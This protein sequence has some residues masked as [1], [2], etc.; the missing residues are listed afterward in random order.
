MEDM[1]VS[2]MHGGDDAWAT[3]QSWVS[4]GLAGR[5]GT[6]ECQDVRMAALRD[7][8]RVSASHRRIDHGLAST[9]GGQTRRYEDKLGTVVY[10]IY[11]KNSG[12]QQ[13]FIKYY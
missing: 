8:L 6:T 1:F 5:E 12:N 10:I 9:D 4:F 13:V 3:T 7:E 11:C 2:N